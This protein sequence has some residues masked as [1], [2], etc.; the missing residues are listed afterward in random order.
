[1][2]IKLDDR[3][4]SAASYVKP[5]A[6]VIDVGTDHAYLPVYLL[7]AGIAKRALATD[8]NLG[9][10]NNAKETIV[11]HGL[12]DCISTAIANGLEGAETFSA[13]TVMICGMGGELIA[14]II[15]RAPFVKEQKV[16][17]ILQPMTFGDH[18]R[19]YLLSHGFNIIDER[20]STDNNKLYSCL[21]AEYD[22]IVREYSEVELLI[23]RCNLERHEDPLRTAF[24]ERE[25]RKLEGIVRGK[26][27][28]GVCHV[29]EEKMIAALRGYL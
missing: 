1:M 7:E 24:I 12:E 13:D 25:I 29:A 22:G 26:Q 15:D 21:C 27:S 20:L 2:N 23:G 10:L 3:L 9:P 17:L 8:V 16:R 18:L 4:L 14:D 11:A 5:N 28:G 19:K 6:V